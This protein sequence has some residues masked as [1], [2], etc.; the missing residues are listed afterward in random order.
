MPSEMYVEKV[1]K[2]EKMNYKLTIG[3]LIIISLCE[4]NLAKSNVNY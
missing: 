1:K 3:I 2:K 4:G